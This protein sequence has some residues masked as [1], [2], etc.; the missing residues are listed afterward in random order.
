MAACAGQMHVELG[1]GVL[2]APP[3]PLSRTQQPELHCELRVQV[4]A[5]DLG[6]YDQFTHR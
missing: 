2:H 6:S 4:A 1:P 3:P 5:H